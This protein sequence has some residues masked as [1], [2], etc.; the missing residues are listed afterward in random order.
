MPISAWHVKDTS[1]AVAFEWP[2]PQKTF[3]HK[4]IA[5]ANSQ[6]AKS[7]FIV[8]DELKRVSSELGH[9]LRAE[10]L[11]LHS[12]LGDMIPNDDDNETDTK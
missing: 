1:E 4:R 11:K 9:S 10:F 6:L 12:V 2:T 7:I 8:A 3:Q 5:E